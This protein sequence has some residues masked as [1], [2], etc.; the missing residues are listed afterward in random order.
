MFGKYKVDPGMKW[1]KPHVFGPPTTRDTEVPISPGGEG[2]TVVFYIFTCT[3]CNFSFEIRSSNDPLIG[4]TV[5]YPKATEGKM[6]ELYGC[7]V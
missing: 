6:T 2:Y 1:G 5:D 4:D 7:P 3:E